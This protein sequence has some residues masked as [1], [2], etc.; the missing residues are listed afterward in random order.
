MKGKG[1]DSTGTK[2]LLGRK[3][4]LIARE[5]TLEAHIIGGARICNATAEF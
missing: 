4:V 3:R 2:Q 5:A 1:E